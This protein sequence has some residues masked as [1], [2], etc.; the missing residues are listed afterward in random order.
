[1]VDLFEQPDV[2]D[3]PYPSSNVWI[4]EQVA[5]WLTLGHVPH[6][7][8]GHLSREHVLQGGEQNGDCETKVV[9]HYFGVDKP[10]FLSAMS[11]QASKKS[12]AGQT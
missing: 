6:L 10:A 8:H 3:L 7:T 1:M 9:H 5:L 12:V 4:L 11:Q 2:E